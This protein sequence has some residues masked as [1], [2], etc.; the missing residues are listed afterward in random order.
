MDETPERHTTKGYFFT[1][2]AVLGGALLMP[3]FAVSFTI[4]A[5]LLLLI[6]TP[7]FLIGLAQYRQQKRLPARQNMAISYSQE[8][9][10]VSQSST[11]SDMCD[12][13]PWR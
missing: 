10:A 1:I 13:A 9:L 2:I 8:P 3:F 5:P 12:N 4:I 7:M 11:S 6:L